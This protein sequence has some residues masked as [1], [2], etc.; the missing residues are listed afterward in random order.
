MCEMGRTIDIRRIEVIDDEVAAMFGAMTP[1]RRVELGLDQ[2]AFAKKVR[3][4]GRE[5]VRRNQVS[6]SETQNR[7]AS[8][9]VPGR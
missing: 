3:E 7:S 9:F 5:W 6:D 8:H 2:Q 4:A 1:Q